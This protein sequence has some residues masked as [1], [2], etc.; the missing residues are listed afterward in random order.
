MILVILLVLLFILVMIRLVSNK[1]EGFENTAVEPLKKNVVDTYKRFTEFYNPF[2]S[3]WEKAIVSSASLDIPREPLESPD[4]KPSGTPPTISRDQQNAYIT[5][6]SQQLKKPLP[7]IT[8]PL[9]PSTSINMNMLPELL[10]RIPKDPTPYQNALSWMNDQLRSAQDNLK[11]ALQGVPFNIESFEDKCNG[12]SQCLINNEEFI[13]KVGD[14]VCS[15]E[16]RK[17]EQDRNQQQEELLKR[18]NAFITNTTLMKSLQD[19]QALVKQAEKVKQQ[20]ESGELYKQV[21]IS[22]PSVQLPPLLPEDLALSKLQ[23][24][25]PQEYNNLKDNYKPWFNLKTLTEQINRSV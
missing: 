16:K 1:I 24:T 2:L 25:N 4:Q 21:K 18:M 12:T 7:P 6:L 20:A 8:D 14:Q 3:S 13:R 9:P 11:K 10:Q 19:N 23:Q 5:K 22:E 17:Q 15:S